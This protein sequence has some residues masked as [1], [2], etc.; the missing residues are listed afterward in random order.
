MGA[1]KYYVSKE[2]GRLGNQMLMFADMVDGWG[3]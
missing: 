3:S 2:V 1:Y